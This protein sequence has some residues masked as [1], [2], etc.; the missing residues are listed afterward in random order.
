MFAV[1]CWSAEHAQMADCGA[2]SCWS[3][4]PER[5]YPRGMHAPR[6]AQS[7][8]TAWSHHASAL[9]PCHSM[10]VNRFA[11]TRGMTG[12]ALRGAFEAASSHA[13]VRGGIVC[14]PA[15]HRVGMRVQD[16]SCCTICMLD[17]VEMYVCIRSIRSHSAIRDL[18]NTFPANYDQF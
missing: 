11:G 14:M 4:E 9:L 6:V 7:Q 5:D 12:S 15:E 10:H 16:D 2:C 8:S 1:P 3:A 18:H 17:C 13:R